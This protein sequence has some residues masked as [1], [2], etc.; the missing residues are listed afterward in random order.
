MPLPNFAIIG[1]AKSATTSLYFYLKQHPQ[2]YMSAGCKEPNFF[3]YGEAESPRFAGPVAQLPDP[4]AS[5]LAAYTALFAGVKQQV[6]V[7]EA[8]TSNLESRRAHQR[9]KAYLPE[10]KFIVLLR[11][12]AARAWSQFLHT[13]RAGWEPCADFRQ[14]WQQ[15]QTGK[16]QGWWHF[17]RYYENGLYAERLASFYRYFP[18]DQVRIYLYEEFA[19]NNTGVL[20]DIFQFLG[21]DP[22][23]TPDLS[24]RHNLARRVRSSRLNWLLQRNRQS[25]RWLIHL[26]PP[27]SR[28]TLR[29]TLST[30]NQGEASTL[31]PTLYQF[32]TNEFQAEI[33]QLQTVIQ[34]DISHWLP[35]PKSQSGT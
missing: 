33:R 9:M 15:E 20:H 5:S 22:T 10:A 2:I 13:R 7:G 29:Q 32:I 21:V 8:S 30:L 6:A 19:Q 17:L 14:A 4:Y 24:I 16:R 25:I 27:L 23:F 28:R 31:D 35:C 18:H 34:R 26:L 3:A 1:T 12:P 11:H